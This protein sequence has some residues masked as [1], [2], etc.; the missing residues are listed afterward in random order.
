MHD[1]VDHGLEDQ[2]QFAAVQRAVEVGAQGV[3][4]VLLHAQ[5]V[6][7]PVHGG[8]PG[9]AGAAQGEVAAAQGLTGVDVG[10]QRG[11]AGDG[12][13]VQHA[14]GDRQRADGGDEAGGDGLGVGDA[15]VDE[16]HEVAV[17][18]A[19]QPVLTA[20]RAGQP[21]RQGAE[22]GRLRLG[23]E[24]LGG[25]PVDAD[26]GEGEGPPLALDGAQASHQRCPVGQAGDGVGERELGQFGVEAGRGD[27]GGDVAAVQD[28]RTDVGVGAQVADGG[29]DQSPAAVGITDAGGADG[30][31]VGVAVAVEPGD[32]AWAV[33]GVHGV[34]EDRPTKRAGSRPSMSATACEAKV[35]RSFSSRM[36]TGSTL[37]FTSVRN[38]DWL[39]CRSP[40]RRRWRA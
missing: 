31:L 5:G 29:L 6:V 1:D 3:A 18:A 33:V 9:G 25:Q 30:D 39:R 36:T 17:L 16:D 12:G 27:A 21:G 24:R 2:P 10:Q 38:E 28:E 7:V 11:D 14:A 37:L 35:M 32:E 22:R 4:P 26:D 40:W 23:G 20:Q 15:A 8:R 13:Q 34:D 19:G